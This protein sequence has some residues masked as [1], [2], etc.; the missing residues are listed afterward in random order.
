MLKGLAAAGAA[1]STANLAI[2]M[3][4][5]N[6]EHVYRVLHTIGIDETD[7]WGDPYRHGVDEPWQEP[8]RVIARI[9]REHGWATISLTGT[10]D[11][12]VEA[13]RRV[14]DFLPCESD[15]TLFARSLHG[16]RRRNEVVRVRLDRFHLELT[17]LAHHLMHQASARWVTV[18]MTDPAL[19]QQAVAQALDLLAADR[20]SALYLL[21]DPLFHGDREQKLGQL[22]WLLDGQEPGLVVC[23][24]CFRP[25]DTSDPFL[26]VDGELESER[27]QR[28][29]NALPR[30]SAHATCYEAWQSVH[31]RAETEYD[32]YWSEYK[33]APWI[34]LERYRLK[35]ARME[36]R[37]DEVYQLQQAA[38]AAALTGR[39]QSAAW[40]VLSSS[41]QKRGDNRNDLIAGLAVAGASVRL[42]ASPDKQYAVVS[43]W[44]A[45]VYGPNDPMY[46]DTVIPTAVLW[47]SIKAQ[48]R[49]EVY[50]WATSFDDDPD[51][52]YEAARVILTFTVSGNDIVLS[53]SSRSPGGPESITLSQSALRDA[54]GQVD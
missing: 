12:D 33:P 23:R 48:G 37:S 29:C 38:E 45:A 20:S 22:N 52:F 9:N 17:L 43:F 1:D 27:H 51:S 7:V 53:L 44:H 40:V 6:L 8:T 14:G 24:H 50:G 28:E 18:S 3:T 54:L 5:E 41:Q 13:Y 10:E 46:S 39:R 30:H 36:G 25:V 42:E 34:D 15:H 19:R 11:E 4:A 32:H 16:Q 49:A 47:R 21:A 2:P 35:W 31:G 26:T